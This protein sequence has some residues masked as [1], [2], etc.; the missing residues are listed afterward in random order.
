M[1]VEVRACGAREI[2]KDPAGEKLIAEYAAEC[3]I[4]L[5]GKPAP[6]LD[7][8]ENIEVSGLGQCFSV[9]KDGQLCGF[10]MVIT[11]VV[12]HYALSCATTESIFV[13]R[14]GSGGLELMSAL[15]EYATR[16]G[17]TS[18]FY[19]VPVGSRMARLLFLWTDRYTHTNH[20]FCRRLAA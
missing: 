8:Y 20:V 10:A 12:P 5:V 16:V 6:R 9:R 3:A 2:F 7:M 14:D 15:E 18:I 4:A 13:S 17:C 11:A 19:A 1:S